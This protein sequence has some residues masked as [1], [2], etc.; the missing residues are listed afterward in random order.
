MFG[1]FQY[2]TLTFEMRKAIHDALAETTLKHVRQSGDLFHPL[3]YDPAKNPSQLLETTHLA[4]APK[5]RSEVSGLAQIAAPQL[6][7]CI[8]EAIRSRSGLGDKLREHLAAGTNIF[9]VSTHQQIQDIA[10]W[11]AAVSNQLEE[12]HWYEQ[13]GHIISRGVTTI[14]AFGMAASE[15]L[16]K[17]G[18]VFMS[19]PRTETIENLG[20]DETIVKTNNK[21]MRG[22]VATWLRQD[23]KH[24]LL[25]NQLGMSLNIAWSGKTDAVQ[26][27]DIGKPEGV[28]FGRVGEGTLRIVRGGLVLPIVMWDGDEPFCEIGEFTT[29]RDNKDVIRVQQWQ[30]KSLGRF[31]GLPS[32]AIKIEGVRS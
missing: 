8:E 6:F 18:H 25:P 4:P 28:T 13:N 1:E 30:A 27:G 19:F 17:D 22:E 32:T 14:E 10:I 2:E 11:G 31:L 3:D 24:R 21:R 7:P 26:K 23:L 15:V 9:S 20:F 16:Q 5:D 12:D 29:V